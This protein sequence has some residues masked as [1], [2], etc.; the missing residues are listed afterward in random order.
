MCLGSRDVE[1]IEGNKS[2]ASMNLD[3]VFSVGRPNLQSRSI[4]EMGWVD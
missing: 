4:L 3:I 2:R 1:G